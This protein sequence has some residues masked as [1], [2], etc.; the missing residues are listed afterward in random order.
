MSVEPEILK[1]SISQSPGLG[2]SSF[3]VFGPSEWAVEIRFV[4]CDQLTGTRN[5]ILALAAGA[6]K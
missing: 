6:A 3:L 1:S 5:H 4:R 2:V